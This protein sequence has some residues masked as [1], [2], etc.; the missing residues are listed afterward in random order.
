MTKMP[1]HKRNKNNRGIRC[2]SRFTTN[3]IAPK[4]QKCWTHK[5]AFQNHIKNAKETKPF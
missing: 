3:N 1:K 2:T 5:I 4:L